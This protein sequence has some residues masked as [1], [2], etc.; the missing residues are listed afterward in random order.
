MSESRVVVGGF[1]SRIEAELA[2]SRLEADGIAAEVVS[3]DAGGTY[4]PLHSRGVRVVVAAEDAERAAAVLASIGPVAD[5][6]PGDLEEAEA[7]VQGRT[8]GVGRI[9]GFLV[10]SGIAI[11]VFTCA[12]SSSEARSFDEGGRELAAAVED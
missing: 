5:D 9:V 7:A 11:A 2:K 10:I 3:D 4:P 12:R 1:G 6:A 8:A